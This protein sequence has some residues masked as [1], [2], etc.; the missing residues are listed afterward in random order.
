M[1]KYFGGGS[2]GGGGLPAP[3]PAGD[4][5]TSNGSAWVSAGATP[6]D[7]SAFAA[8]APVV[9]IGA[10]VVNPSFTAAET[11]APTVLGL[12][13]NDNAEN[14]N[15]VATPT[16]FSSS[17]SY[18]K[19]ANNAAV[20]F[21]LA[22]SDGITPDS[23]QTTISWRPLVY[24]GVAAA[25]ANT[26]AGIKALASSA[27][28]ASRAT[29]YTDNAGVAQYLYWAAPASYGTPTFTVGGFAGGFSLVSNTIALTLNGVTQ[30]YQL[31]Q[32]DVAALGS[33]AVVV[34]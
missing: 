17:Q 9:M 3:G 31:W 15:V 33:T 29:S 19:T 1:A 24:H 7:I 14:K 8:V 11:Q 30:N 18:T 6:F 16:A 27:L 23:R 10:N 20:T 22:G 28:Q 12:T 34:S 26:E 2:G 5:L 4:V 21:T 32:S 13:N 25:G